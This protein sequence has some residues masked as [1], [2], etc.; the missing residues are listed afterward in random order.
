MKVDWNSRNVQQDLI[1]QRHR[2]QEEYDSIYANLPRLQKEQLAAQSAL[3]QVTSAVSASFDR[4][5]EID[6]KL[7]QLSAKIND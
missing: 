2:W 1:G 3:D 4:I 6:A 7:R 5:D